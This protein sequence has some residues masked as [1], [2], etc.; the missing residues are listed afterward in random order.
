MRSEPEAAASPMPE[1]KVERGGDR[2]HALRAARG[3]SR[4][5]ISEAGISLVEARSHALRL[6]LRR[7]SKR[8]ENVVALKAWV[9][10]VREAVRPPEP[11]KERAPVKEK[12][13]E[14]ALGKKPPE[15]KARKPKTKPRKKEA[16]QKQ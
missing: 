9:L 11:V 10:R 12:P 15:K 4:G 2:T 13:E 6:D 8:E 14:E 1:A 5:E 7:R 3:F 16:R